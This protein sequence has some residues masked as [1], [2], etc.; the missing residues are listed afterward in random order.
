MALELSCIHL[1]DIII[2][3]LSLIF[4][5]GHEGAVVVRQAW[6]IDV[7][8]LPLLRFCIDGRGESTCLRPG[9][10]GVALKSR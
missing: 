10:G 5:M 1:P 9:L 7:I 2:F 6:V 8:E 4:D 3:L